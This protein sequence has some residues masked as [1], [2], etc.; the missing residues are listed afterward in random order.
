MDV[1]PEWWT[2]QE[3]LQEK[4][5]N[6]SHRHMSNNS[7]TFKQ[8]PS[9]EVLHLVFELMKY[10][11]EPGFFNLEAAKK[12]RPNAKGLNPCGEILLR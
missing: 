8:K 6:L 4:Q 12:R 7:I 2:D 9:Q 3:M 1:L 10:T 11:G 5:D